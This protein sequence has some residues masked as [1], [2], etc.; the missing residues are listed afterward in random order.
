MIWPI[1]YLLLLQLRNAKWIPFEE[2]IY[3]DIDMSVNWNQF[4]KLTMRI[5]WTYILYVGADIYNVYLD[6]SNWKKSGPEMYYLL[7]A[8]GLN[9]P[10]CVSTA[11]ALSIIDF[12]LCWLCY[13]CNNGVDNPRHPINWHEN[14][15]GNYHRIWLNGRKTF[16]GISKLHFTL[17]F[18]SWRINVHR[19][20]NN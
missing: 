11:L 3:S 18:S 1:Y 4:F 6:H 13:E 17:S 15:G 8:A 14:S 9:G 20:G 12:E 2:N 7:A 5:G 19:I 10:E 16:R